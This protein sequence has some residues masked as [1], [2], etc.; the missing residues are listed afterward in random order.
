MP[1]KCSPTTFRDRKAICL[2]SDTLQVITLTGCGHLASVRI[3]D[4][5]VN[6]MWEPPWAGIEPEDWDL[7]RH[8]P[9]YGPGEGRLLASLAG[10]SLCLNH[11]GDLSETEIEANGYFHGEASNLPWTVFDQ[12]AADGEARLDY[13]LE[14]PEARMRFQRTL[15]IR[16]GESTLYFTESTTNLTRIDSPFCCQQH[17]TLGPPFVEGGVSRVDLPAKRGQTNPVVI[18]ETDPIKPDQTYDWPNA[19]LQAGGT[20][21]MR[22]Y[23]EDHCMAVVSV[24]LEPE[25]E[26]A[27]TAVSNPKL[28]LLVVY[29]F[30][31]EIFPWTTLWYEHEAAE[32][33]PYSNRATTWGVEFGSVAQAVKFMENLTAGP[34]LGQPRCGT[35][36]ALHTVDI[37]YQAHM[38]KIPSDWQG[39]ARIEHDKGETIAWE[40]GSDRSA[41][42][43]SDWLVS[44]QTSLK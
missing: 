12:R 36:P 16:E 29:A 33:L 23:P 32:F 4:V 28:G 42:T 37:N 15:R 39:V 22:L 14:L 44:T 38:L 34:L 40:L 35:L 2:E 41:R 10:H 20:R 13:G 17:V 25:E 8:V 1:P 6:P 5:D 19:P 3:P 26:F 27:Y 18:H 31:R 24:L 7:D 9:I 30:P 11:F 21:D 43:P